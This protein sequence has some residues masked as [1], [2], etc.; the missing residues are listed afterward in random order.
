MVSSFFRDSNINFVPA[1]V[2]GIYKATITH[3]KSCLNEVI[4]KNLD[5]EV[6][7]VEA[8]NDLAKINLDTRLT[9]LNDLIEERMKVDFLI[10]TIKN[11][12]TIKDSFSGENITYYF[13][14]Q[15]NKDYT[16]YNEYVLK[17]LLNANKE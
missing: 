4:G 12:S 14:Y 7:A 2:N 6:I 13:G 8:Q 15:V 17:P 5:D 16:E 9:I 11:Q 3:K 10:E 1:T